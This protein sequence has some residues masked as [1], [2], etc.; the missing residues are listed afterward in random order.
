MLCNNQSSSFSSLHPVYIHHS[1]NPHASPTHL[2]CWCVPEKDMES[3][4]E[5]VR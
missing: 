3:V 2:S 4:S 5:L 1:T